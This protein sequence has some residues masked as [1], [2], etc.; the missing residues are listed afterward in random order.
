M[1]LHKIFMQTVSEYCLSNS[2]KNILQL[3]LIKH[4]VRVNEKKSQEV[5]TS[6]F[7]TS[8]FQHR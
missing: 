1:L 4:T 8:S 3:D 2:I 5:T 6:F 7:I